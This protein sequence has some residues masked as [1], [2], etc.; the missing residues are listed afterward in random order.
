[1][2]VEDVE[3]D[4]RLRAMR[5]MFVCHDEATLAAV[6]QTIKTA[7]TL[8]LLYQG[9]LLGVL[10]FYHTTIRPYSA[11]DLRLAQAIADQAAIAVKNT[12][13]LF[14]TQQRAAEANLL[15]RVSSTVS[16][17]LDLHDIFRRIVDEVSQTFGYSHGSI[18]RLEADYR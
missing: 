11:E 2:V 14:Q 13:L 5:E 15:N 17:T 16:G 6:W 10:A 8:P 9:E 1:M 12:T 3:R 4:P 18:H 7:T